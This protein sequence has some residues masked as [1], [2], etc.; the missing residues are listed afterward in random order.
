M[1]TLTTLLAGAAVAISVCLPPG[2]VLV[3]TIR[4]G[5][6]GGFRYALLVQLGSILG[7]VAWCLAAL[8]GLAP[9]VAIP[10]VRLLLGGA[11]MAMLVWLGAQGLR[12]ALS[13]RALSLLVPAGER[14]AL[15]A[16]DEGRQAFRSGTAI[17]FANPLA[18]GFWIGIGSVMASAGVAGNSPAQTATFVGG[19]LLGVLAWAACVA[20]CFRWFESRLRPDGRLARAAS[21]VCGLCLI[22]LGLGLGWQVFGGWLI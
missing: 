10:W 14:L 8:F 6:Q 20:I 17:S 9:L 16:P 2:P 7:D 1:S 11:G 13:T 18:I 5:L 22:G 19:Y 3:E 15:A 12:E 21:G 4:R